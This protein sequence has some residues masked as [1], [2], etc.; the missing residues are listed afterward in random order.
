MQGS[1]F[2]LMAANAA[3]VAIAVFAYLQAGAVAAVRPLSGMV[4]DQR[5]PTFEW[6]GPSGSYEVL[7]DDDP[8]FGSPMSFSASGNSM[9]LPQELEFGTYWWKVRSGDA[10][11]GPSVL[12]VVS[13]VALSRPAPGT[14]VNSGNTELLLFRSG[15]TGAFTLAVNRTMDIGGE[16]SVKA[17]Q[18]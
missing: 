17:E 16:E 4:T 18:R 2:R 3:V 7:I 5:S 11:A 6:S 8:G 10:E 14:L 12:T 9:R 1:T 13:S 15:M